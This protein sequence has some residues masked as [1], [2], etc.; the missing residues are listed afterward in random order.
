MLH[1]SFWLQKRQA[2][3]DAPHI[4]ICY[5]SASINGHACAALWPGGGRWAATECDAK[6]G[7]V[8]LEKASIVD[9][10]FGLIMVYNRRAYLMMSDRGEYG[11]IFMG[12][13]WLRTVVNNGLY[14]Q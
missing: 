2:N 12:L 9:L 5:R 4:E 14:S 7:K 1:G 3:V 6:V 13:E 10:E 11:S 8:T